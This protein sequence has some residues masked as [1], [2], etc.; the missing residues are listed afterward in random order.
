MKEYI[1]PVSIISSCGVTGQENLLLKQKLQIG[2]CETRTAV[3]E[4]GSYIILDFGLEMCGGVRILAFLSEMAGV[5]IRFG[6]SLE[7]C[8]SEIGGEKNATNDHSLRDFHKSLPS[9]SDMTFGSTGFRF[10]RLDFDSRAVIKSIVCEN[11]ILKKR[12]VYTY[13][14][15]DECIKQIY[16]A[17]KRT[18]DLCAAGDYIWDGVK[19]DRLV[20]IGDM[21]PETLALLTLYKEFPAIEKSLDFV[22]EQTPI[23]SWMNG[24]PVYSMWWVIILADYYKG[25]KR[26]NFAKKQ[27][28]YLDS[29]LTLMLSCVDENGEMSYPFYFVDWST[30]S[31]HDA[32]HGVRAINIMAAK[33]ALYLLKEFEKDTEKAQE[34]LD[35]LLKVDICPENSK[36]VLGLKFFATKLTEKDKLALVKDGAR[37]M[38]TFMSY[39]ILKAVASFDRDASVSMMKEFY[40]AMLSKGATTFWEDFD[41]SWAE[42]SSRIDEFCPDGVADIHGDFGAWCYKGFRH[43]LCHGW[44][45]G[46]LQ[47]IKEEC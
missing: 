41:M 35:R 5:R 30:H 42:N 36:Q 25:T 20:W 45:A 6:E 28:D 22:K 40:G 7:E 27:L 16:T 18:I 8:S 1:F 32:V 33:S 31:S 26:K 2:L 11:N 17:A 13:D 19:R 23:P 38:S 12:A 44:S 46:V 9:Y 21:H 39:Y 37:G 4:K 14:G 24:Y 43:S 10:V 29:L 47:F 15:D 34:L 3:F